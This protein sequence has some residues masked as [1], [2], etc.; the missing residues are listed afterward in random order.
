MPLKV[1]E[2]A[3]ELPEFASHN[4]DRVT[5]R[6]EIRETQTAA[7]R[8]KKRSSSA[9]QP[10]ADLWEIVRQKRLQMAEI[11]RNTEVN[12]CEPYRR[13]RG[14]WRTRPLQNRTR[15]GR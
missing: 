3:P 1:V 13:S 2:E 6:R 7:F 4:G 11:G 5:D 12:D 15:G 8:P 14:A 10:R 9:S